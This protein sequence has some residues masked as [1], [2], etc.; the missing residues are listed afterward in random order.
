MAA[1]RPVRA[2]RLAALAQPTPPPTLPVAANVQHDGTAKHR[3]A[4]GRG[5][6][7][8]DARGGSGNRSEPGGFVYLGV[9]VAAKSTPPPVQQTAR[10]ATQAGGAFSP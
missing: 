10:A 7:A 3:R 1:T 5:V 4:P 8:H 9:P 6:V 2:T